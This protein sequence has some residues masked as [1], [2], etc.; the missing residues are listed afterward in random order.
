[1]SM[2]DLFESVKRKEIKEIKEMLNKKP[3][4][5]YSAKDILDKYTELAVTIESY[6]RD[7][8]F[9]YYPGEYYHFECLHKEILKRIVG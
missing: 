6:K 2:E 1:M 7:Q 4:S 9:H 3:L 5:E 8:D